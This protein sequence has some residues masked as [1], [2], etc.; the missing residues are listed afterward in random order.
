MLSFFL[1]VAS[2][3]A[4]ETDEMLEVA[5]VPTRAGRL[6][7]YA[8]ELASVYVGAFT[9]LVEFE[10]NFDLRGLLNDGNGMFCD[11]DGTDLFELMRRNLL[12]KSRSEAIEFFIDHNKPEIKTALS[13]ILRFTNDLV[14]ATLMTNRIDHVTREMVWPIYLLVSEY[15]AIISRPCLSHHLPSAF[16]DPTLYASVFNLLPRKD[17]HVS[18]NVGDGIIGNLHDENR[19]LPWMLGTL[20]SWDDII[21]HVERTHLFDRDSNYTRFVDLRAGC[22]VQLNS[23]FKQAM[24]FPQFR[25]FGAVDISRRD[26]MIWR[27]DARILIHVG[28]FEVFSSVS[29]DQKD[30]RFVVNGVTHLLPVGAG[31]L[32]VVTDDGLGRPGMY[33]LDYPRSLLAASRLFSSTGLLLFDKER[34]K[35]LLSRGRAE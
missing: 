14:I 11:T 22:A 6:F 15:V 28:D 18:R 29:A 1:L 7:D 24:I 25:I 34:E 10:R 19:Q 13:R 16:R 32:E 30:V 27:G 8:G 23:R 17:Y 9:S 3:F 12:L 4:P 31:Y 20:T 5:E 21:I 35:R 2:V 33:P 26:L